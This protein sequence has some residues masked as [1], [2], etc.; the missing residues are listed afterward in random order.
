M[1]PILTTDQ[2]R[3]QL[4]IDH[5]ADDAWLELAIAGATAGAASWCGGVENL[6]DD[7]GSPLPQAVM[8]CLVEVAYQYRFRTG[9]DVAYLMAWHEAGYPLSPGATSYLVSLHRVLSA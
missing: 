2:C 6:F 5:D 1:T 7:T 3:D 8:A 4:R 9:P